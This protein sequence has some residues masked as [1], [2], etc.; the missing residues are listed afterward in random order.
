MM[1]GDIIA[2]SNYGQGTIFTVTIPVTAGNE[3]NL[4]LSDKEQDTITM[5]APDA[6]ILVTDDNEFNLRV[7]SGLLN[8][9]EIN[10]ETAISG[11]K[12]IELIKEN[13]Y[14]IV[15]MDHMMPEMDGIETVHK[16]RAMGGKY[17]KL[18]IIA[19]TANAIKGAREMFIDN[20]FDDFLSKP[21]DINEMREMVKRYLPHD[22][23]KITV[24]KDGTQSSSAIED[25]IR[26]KS[27]STF[28]KENRNAFME[29]TKAL[30][31]QDIKTAHRIAHTIK[32]SAG[33]L[34][35]KKLQEVAGSLE[36]SFKDGIAN[37]TP[38]QL[39]IFQ[40]ELSAALFEYET[41]LKNS[42]EEKQEIVILTDLE[43]TI[44][45][46][47]LEPLLKRDDF[48]AAKYVDKLRTISGME[49][50][51]EAI[52]EYDFAGALAILKEIKSA[53]V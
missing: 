39:R 12:A 14:D 48:G 38:Q 8:L 11:F 13:D 18:I 4:H 7:T 34:D 37:H 41:R 50:L 46:D 2:E 25:E 28:V 45:L 33:Y 21:I 15:F 51:A 35:K 22:K 27:I 3:E 26:S 47:E 30:S 40:N 16:I 43:K 6:K 9:M 52:D 20:S 53:N 17:E 1:G 24:S 29:M 31:S 23:L 44:L 10:T 49:D 5:S 42:E 32:S 36:E 19:L